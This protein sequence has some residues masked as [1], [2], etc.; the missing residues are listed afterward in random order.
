MP[1]ARTCALCRCVVGRHPVVCVECHQRAVH[2][3]GE[4]IRKLQGKV[5]TEKSANA[6]LSLF[7]ENSHEVQYAKRQPHLG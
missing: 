4:E 1:Q 7:A 2:T 6:I 3:L 5:L